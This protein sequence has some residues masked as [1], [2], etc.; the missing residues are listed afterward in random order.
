M[1]GKNK[2]T[3]NKKRKKNRKSKEKGQSE[4]YPEEKLQKTDSNV[5]VGRTVDDSAMGLPAQVEG[6]VLR[7][8]THLRET[9]ISCV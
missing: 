5:M 7:K 1:G 6:G 3:G 2:K 8:S 4:E 9:K